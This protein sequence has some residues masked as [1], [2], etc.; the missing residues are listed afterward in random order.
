MPGFGLCYK[1]QAMAEVEK[2]KVITRVEDAKPGIW[3]EKMVVVYP[4]DD[5][6][7][8][9][10]LKQLVIDRGAEFTQLPPGLEEIVKKEGQMAFAFWVNKLTP[11]VSAKDLRQ[12]NYRL[13]ITD[14]K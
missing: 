7:Q 13:K 5:W 4:K 11:Q 12:G 8:G 14:G 3:Q 9:E 10:A 6:A 1:W 2:W